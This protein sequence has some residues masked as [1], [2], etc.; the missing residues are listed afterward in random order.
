M[1]PKI[2]ISISHALGTLLVTL[3]FFGVLPN[4]VTAATYYVA[5]NGSDTNPGTS[6]ASWKTFSK[7]HTVATSGDVVVF[8]NGTYPAYQ[9]ITKAGITWKSENPLGARF[10]GG[11]SPSLLKG[12][13]KNIV[14]ARETACGTRSVYIPLLTI[15]ASN[16]IVDGISFRNSCGSGILIDQG[17]KNIVFKNNQVDWTFTRGMKIFPESSDI[18]LLN[19]I[20]TRMS[21]NDQ[22]H[23]YSKNPYSVNGS[24]GMHGANILVKGNIIA[25][26]RGEISPS[27][28][29][30]FT[31]EENIVVG[32]KNNLYPGPGLNNLIRN[33]LF[34]NPESVKNAGTHWETGY[35]FDNNWRMVTRN[36]QTASNLY[37]EYVSGLK[38]VVYYNNLIINSLV[39]FDGG[40]GNAGYVS[41][42]LGV[43]FGFNTVIAGSQHDKTLSFGFSQRDFGN[44][45]ITGLVENNIF[46]T[47]KRPATSIGAGYDGNDNLKFRNNIW[48]T[49]V[50]QNVKGPGDI[51]TNNPGLTNAVRLL[52]TL[53]IPGIGVADVD[54]DG[55]KAAM[56]LND[57]RLA[58]N[59]PAI[60]K[61][62]TTTTPNGVPIPLEPK[63]KDLV[64]STRISTPDIGA[65]EYG[66]IVAPTT[67]TNIPN[68]PVPS[69]VP[70]TQPQTWDLNNSGKVDI[71]DF[72]YLVKGFGS[73]FNALDITLFKL[74]LLK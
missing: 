41:E 14:T 3:V 10:D 19:N 43:Y 40:H 45:V 42:T 52:D 21:F 59:S 57:Y 35:G 23:Y 12:E 67:P 25:W 61:A 64:G 38:N 69:T 68:S 46:D 15:R 34:Y 56:K 27:G 30:N 48:P 26:G 5:P 37:K 63:S 6:A 65:L 66:G 60:N 7:A 54:I 44:P 36:E 16:T 18:Q 70:S 53:K 74:A 73:Q 20:I 39:S 9:S 32:N 13:W 71:F 17:A 51:Y 8:K 2:R 11:F 58:V 49:S 50:P 28:S 72:S 22:W 29:R 24:M 55:L 33:N 62:T 4:L 31:F 1:T 47:R